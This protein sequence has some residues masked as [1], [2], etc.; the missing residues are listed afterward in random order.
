MLNLKSLGFI[1]LGLCLAANFTTCSNHDAENYIDEW[2]DD[3]E[4]AASKSFNSKSQ[5]SG[6][7]TNLIDVYAEYTSNDTTVL[8]NINKDGSWDLTLKTLATSDS[9]QGKLV[10]V[11]NSTPIDAAT[12][13]SLEYSVENSFTY[14]TGQGKE[15]KKVETGGTSKQLNGINH[16]KIDECIST[17]NKITF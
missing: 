4:G 17:L 14:Y 11:R 2:V 8:E 10:V 15:I 16:D 12:T 9:V 6:N 13:Y 5:I 7:F 1:A 3:L